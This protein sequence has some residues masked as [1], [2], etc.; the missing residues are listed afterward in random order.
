[1]TIVELIRRDH[2]EVADLF[3]HLAVLARD[4][5]RADEA[6]RIASR[7]VAVVRVHCRAE[8]RVLYRAL[9]TSVPALCTFGLA[10]P[11]EHENLDATLDKLLVRRT[12][13]EEYQV[14]VR[15]ARDLFERH[16]RQE[17]E[18]EI[19]PLVQ[20]SLSEHEL[21]TLGA[22]MLAEQARVRPAVLRLC[23]MPARAA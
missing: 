13:D 11:H 20:A 15:V 8:E 6:A 10:G 7:L 9:R 19:L 21:R 22:D 18:G 14:I 16:S 4:G 5:R 3:D 2:D 17:E 12:G 23:G 1:M